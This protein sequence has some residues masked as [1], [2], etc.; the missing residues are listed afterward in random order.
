MAK[1]GLRIKKGGK[2]AQTRWVYDEEKDAGSYVE[3]DVTEQAVT[4]LFE[5]CVIED[6][7]TLRDIFLLLNTELDIFDTIIRNWCKEIVTE[8]LNREKSEKKS[9]VEYLELY[10][11]IFKD[12]DY[13]TGKSCLGGYIFPSF[14]GVGYMAEEDQYEH[15]TLMLRKGERQG[16]GVSF[17]PASDLMDLPVKLL[18]EI[19]LYNEEDWKETPQKFELGEYSLG[20][21]LYGIIWELSFHG[22]PAQRDEAAKEIFERVDEIKKELKDES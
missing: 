8:G 10:W 9:E 16:Y 21:V 18:E 17:T 3:R 20:H 22:G 7:V 12:K 4:R 15:D 2:L 19:T 14:H 5:P 13:D 6:G 11:H 1:E